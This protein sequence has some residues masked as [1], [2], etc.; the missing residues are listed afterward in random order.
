MK[1]RHSGILP[2]VHLWIDVFFLNVSFM[3]AY[4]LRFDALFDMP[5]NRYINLLLISNLL[6]LLCTSLF[7]T[8]RFDR[9]SYS[10]NHQTLKVLKVVV[11][12]G[13][14]M[15]AVFYFSQSGAEYSRQQFI[16]S[17]TFFGLAAVAVR[18]LMLYSIV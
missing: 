5:D 14:M 4:L 10:I 12:H 18:M 7:K 16:Y 9:F 15:L 2:K 8:Y 1:N 11:I 3:V 6:W 17:Y 13:G